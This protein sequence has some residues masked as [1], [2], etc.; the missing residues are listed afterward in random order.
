[1]TGP[2]CDALTGL[3]DREIFSG[4][5]KEALTK[6]A[7]RPGEVAVL[8]LDLDRLTTVNES[9][10]YAAGNALICGVAERLQVVV[11]EARRVAR[12]GGDRFAVLASHLPGMPGAM[13]LAAQITNA[14]APPFQLDGCEVY[15]TAGIGI[16][17]T[18]GRACGADELIRDSGLAM[19]RAKRLG[20]GR[21]EVYQP[22]SLDATR[23]RF[24]L[25][26]EIR[27]AHERDQLFLA[28]QPIIDLDTGH[29]AGFEALVRWQH[30]QRGVVPPN[31]FIPA[32]ESSGAIVQIGRWALLTAC[33]QLA[34]WRKRLGPAA[35]PVVMSVN[36]SGIQLQRDDV[37]SAVKAALAAS[38]LPADRLKLELTESVIIEN[39]ERAGMLMHRLKALGVTIAMDDFGTGY[40]SLGALNSLPI[41]ILK[42]DRSFVSGMASSRERYKIVDA[43]L[44]LARS[45]GLS[46]VAE[47][48]ETREE[49]QLLKGLGC[50]M[51][52][53]YLY[54]RPLTVDQAEAYLL[55]TA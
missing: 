23:D 8:T 29:V 53:G 43:V 2:A 13:A 24:V 35:D 20:S 54:A 17:T 51:G 16:A 28:Y 18:Q 4:W 21:I 22:L 38:G 34:D 3:P 55:A 12:I 26:S 5:T 40:S 14:L 19:H 32:A 36:L 33:R 39:P 15:V 27:R 30:P 49:A 11:G 46:T 6:L 42:V 50:Q 52:Q 7:E 1:M 37:V 47:G 25:E 45:L 10:G 9:L 44:S 48:V 41:D 31:D